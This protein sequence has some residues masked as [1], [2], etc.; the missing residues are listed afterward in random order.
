MQNPH[1]SNKDKAIEQFT[2][3]KRTGS[4]VEVF[5]TS[6]IALPEGGSEAFSILPN[7][8]P[9]RAVRLLNRPAGW[10]DPLSQSESTGGEVWA[11]S[12]STVLSF[13]DG[14]A[15]R[16]RGADDCPLAMLRSINIFVLRILRWTCREP[17]ARLAPSMMIT[18]D[19]I[20]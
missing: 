8:N 20:K 9:L 4:S 2:R 17:C 6:D 10:S 13:S 15:G 1:S 14:P 7:E 12:T 11:L 3:P 19:A 5:D 18:E 16:G